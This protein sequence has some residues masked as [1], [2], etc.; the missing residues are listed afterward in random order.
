MPLILRNNIIYYTILYY[1]NTLEYYTNIAGEVSF[2]A[3]KISWN[4]SKRLK[5]IEK[6]FVHELLEADVPQRDLV[7]ESYI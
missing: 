1:T 4:L 5:G 3:V 6:K 7:I 2:A